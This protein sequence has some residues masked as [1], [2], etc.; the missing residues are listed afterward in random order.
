MCNNGFLKSSLQYD[1]ISPYHLKNLPNPSP[2]MIR[3]HN[4][5]VLESENHYGFPK[6]QEKHLLEKPHPIWRNNHKNNK[7]T[8]Y[9]H[10]LHMG[11]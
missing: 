1:D 10:G 6:P 3:N 5:E 9:S 7:I 8:E 2:Q 4:I 11:N